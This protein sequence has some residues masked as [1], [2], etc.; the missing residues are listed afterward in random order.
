M[1]IENYLKEFQGSEEVSRLADEV[2]IEIKN[3]YTQLHEEWS[4]DIQVI[5]FTCIF[6]IASANLIV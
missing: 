5:V 3:S 1:C 2:L 4:R 6:I